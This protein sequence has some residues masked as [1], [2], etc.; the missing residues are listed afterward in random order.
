MTGVAIAKRTRWL[1]LGDWL[2][3]NRWWLVVLASLSV[4]VYEFLEH[5]PLLEE[6][7][8]T[9]AYEL[10]FYGLILPVSAGLIFSQLAA[11][12]SELAW[13]VYSQNLV[14]NLGMQL[15]EV[16]AFHD[17][18]DAF[19]Q[20]VKVVMPLSGATIYSC[21]QQ[22]R[23]YKPILN[24]SSKKDLDIANSPLE[25]NAE[26]CPCLAASPEREGAL[27]QPCR[28]PKMIAL[29][30][31]AAC[32]CLP[33]S[34]SDVPVAG[35]RLYFPHRSQ[36]SQDHTR[37][38]NE[39]A[40]VV[41][42]TFR[43]IQLEQLMKSQNRMVESEQQRIAR[44]VHDTLGHS[45]AFIRLRLD[46]I[47]LEFDSTRADAMRRE[48]ET[49]R[50]VAKEAYDQ[51]REVLIKLSPDENSNLNN[52]L[53]NYAEKISQRANFHVRLHQL[54]ERRGLD[55][56]TQRNIFYIFQE[57]LT[58]IEKHAHARKVDVNLQWLED[59]LE[60]KVEDDG[61]GYDTSRPVQNGHFGLQNK[62]E[63]ALESNARLDIAS[64]PNN[65]TRIILFTPYEG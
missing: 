11:S 23:T 39:V 14:G 30:D 61:I 63:R 37:I 1:G 9:F 48:V 56:L 52:T 43:R 5:Y 18:A 57:I 7:P 34:F 36:P 31:A 55:H 13:M 53:L 59:G 54:G 40:P 24:W 60:I 15:Q 38:L 47:S 50:D 62:K 64:N 20:F 17:L 49:L 10:L 16:H 45:L 58:N 2:L 12:R 46:Q 21:D 32:Y 27:L 3:K 6:S 33:L 35:V 41:A 51:M 65:G 25:C 19:L 29:S 44:D 26:D 8:H 4:F 28:D 22:T 42:S